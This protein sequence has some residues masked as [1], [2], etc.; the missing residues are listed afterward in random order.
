MKTDT[1]VYVDFSALLDWNSKM[2]EINT[3]ALNTL[4]S[5]LKDVEML[6][7]SWS[8]NSANGFLRAS[9]NLIRQ[10]KNYHNDMRNVESFLIKVINTMD[11][12]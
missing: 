11:K 2:D 6:K 8:G 1:S 7:D 9:N 5:F 4:D 12:Q 3:S 10:A